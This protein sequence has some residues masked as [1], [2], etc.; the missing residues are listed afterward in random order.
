MLCIKSRLVYTVS[1]PL[2]T[3]EATFLQSLKLCK[4]ENSDDK[5]VHN[6]KGRQYVV[7]NTLSSMK[8]VFYIYS[9]ISIQ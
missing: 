7:H 8:M 6:T 2:H 4:L 1:Q 5:L 3:Q 9:A